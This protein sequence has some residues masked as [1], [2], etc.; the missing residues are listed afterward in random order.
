MIWL[1]GKQKRRQ[2]KTKVSVKGKHSIAMKY[3][4]I[5]MKI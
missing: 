2:R 3:D 5:A 1:Y 4:S